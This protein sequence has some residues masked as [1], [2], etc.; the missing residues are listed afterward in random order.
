GAV[1]AGALQQSLVALVERHEALRTRFPFVGGEPV[2]VV[3]RAHAPLR[4]L[5]LSSVEPEWRAR[6]VRTALESFAREPFALEEGP[7][8]RA[9]LVRT[10]DERATLAFNV[11][12]EIG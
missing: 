9:L 1:D 4:T 11:H 12:H 5:Y 3:E 10:D 7:L 6:A 2:Q 8:F